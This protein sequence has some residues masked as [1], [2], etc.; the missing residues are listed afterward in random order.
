[1]I[2]NGQIDNKAIKKLDKELKPDVMA[3]HILE[4]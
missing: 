3:F 2:K 4:P 1:M